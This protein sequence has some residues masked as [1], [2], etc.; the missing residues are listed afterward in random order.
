MK[1]LLV[2]SPQPAL[3]AAIGAVLDP[4]AYC[5]V[6]RRDPQSGDDLLLSPGS[7]D[8]CIL[9]VELTSIAPIRIIERL[10]RYLPH[11]PVIV[12]AS[13]SQWEWEEEA[14]LLGVHNILNK[15]VRGR[16]LNALLDRLWSAKTV[17]GRAISEPRPRVEA[18]P[19]PETSPIPVRMLEL[20]RSCSSILSHSLCADSLLREFLLLL[21][22]IIGVN[23][24]A[25]FLRPAPGT[26]GSPSPENARR[27]R[28]AYA[29]GLAPGLLEHFE[30]SLQSG[31]G[32]HVFR[33]G[34]ILRRASEEVD[35]DLQMQKEF[36]LLSA[37][38]A[39]PI[40]DRESFLGLAVFDGR[41]TGEPLSNE[42]LALI[43]HLLEHLGMAIRNIWLHE[44]IA[45]N[46]EM[47][48]EILRQLSS[49]CVVVNHDLRILHANDMALRCFS[50]PG[51]S[52]AF[53]F[54]SLPQSI[55]CKV[56][57][58]LKTGKSIAPC[59]YQPADQPGKVFQIIVTPFC[60]KGSTVPTAALLILEDFSH[61]ERMS[62]L[63]ME[64]SNLRIVKQMAERLAHEIGNA[65]VPISTHQQLL[66]ERL[67]DPEFLTSL[68][69]AMQEGVRRVNRLVT[70]MRFLTADRADNTE[71][72]PVGRLIEEAFCSA[73]VYQPTDSALLQ[74]ENG[75]EGV[76]LTGNHAGL[77]HAFS[78]ILLNSLQANPNACRVQ[79]HA[80]C[81]TDASGSRWAQIDV[82]DN[83]S[84]FSS[85][86]VSHALQPFYT[87]RNVG[88]GLGLAV[89]NRII[90]SH[91][92]KVEI[93]PA[94]SNHC[95]L[96]RVLLPL[97]SANSLNGKAAL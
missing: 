16:L 76:T 27:L 31:I 84:G 92:G 90:Q 95:G 41:V 33:F 51:Q 56:F 44:Q 38:V 74:F 5:L 63:E 55:G 59:K 13:A 77:R 23:R 64:A 75:S 88:L 18:K 15:P 81:A 86:A 52:E 3:A 53:E 82:Q 69:S 9:D 37:Q 25:V 83:G 19:A 93:P 40:L 6:Q 22:E 85:D 61:M 14:Y 49:A 28:S 43:F 34:R 87:T 29:I 79:V 89:T 78:E 58:V 7:I 45:S 46:H 21:R 66:R 50:R 2:I 24:A 32:Q 68:D 48:G 73:R 71:Q 54:S 30:L 12:Y 47:L 10:R 91:H 60:K 62:H 35:R 96:V 8:V 70:Q 80:H 26:M 67:Q 11:C 36:E 17:P 20:F 97:G 94:P 4:A 57:E 1:T 39:I 65:L 72:I 42:E